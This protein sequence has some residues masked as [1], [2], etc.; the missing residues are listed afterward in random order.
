MPCIND[1]IVH[2]CLMQLLYCH[3]SMHQCALHASRLDCQHEL[4]GATDCTGLVAR[5]ACSLAHPAA[6]ASHDMLAALQFYGPVFDAAVKCRNLSRSAHMVLLQDKK[7]TRHSI[8]R[9]KA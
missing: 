2:K 6:G 5:A 7:E 8:T 3:H 1:S 4:L 9:G